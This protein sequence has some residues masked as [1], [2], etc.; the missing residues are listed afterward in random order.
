MGSEALAKIEQF[1][2]DTLKELLNQCTESQ[3]ALFIK[4]YPGGP[5]KIP[6]KKIPRAI[7]QCEN[8][9]IKNKAMAYFVKLLKE[10]K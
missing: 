1:E 6:R 5:Y 4:M 7:Q 3:Q 2:R 9:I 8:T 10:P